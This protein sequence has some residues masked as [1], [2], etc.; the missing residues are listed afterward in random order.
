VTV[1]LLTHSVRLAFVRFGSTAIVADVCAA[2]SD[3]M[4]KI[5]ALDTGAVALE[6]TRALAQETLEPISEVGGLA[7][8]R[9]TCAEADPQRSKEH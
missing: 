9:R 4:P 8:L 5:V 7:R 2:Y 3:A 1:S 6:A